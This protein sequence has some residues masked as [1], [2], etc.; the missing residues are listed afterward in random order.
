MLVR[1]KISHSWHQRLA[2]T[3][4]EY[5]EILRTVPVKCHDD[6]TPLMFQKDRDPVASGPKAS[7]VAWYPAQPRHLRCGGARL[8]ATVSGTSLVPPGL[9]LACT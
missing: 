9:S 6:N 8:S 7:R 4:A 2:Y 1:E 3:Q 5:D